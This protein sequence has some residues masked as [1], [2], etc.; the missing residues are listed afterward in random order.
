MS[1]L[2]LKSTAF[3]LVFMLISNTIF[4][5][6]VIEI[7]YERDRDGQSYTFEVVNSSFINYTVTIDFPT[8]QGLDADVGLPYETTV[9]PGTSRLLKLKPS[10]TSAGGTNFSYTSSFHKGCARTKPDTLF[11]YLLPIS[12]SKSTK[13]SE[14]FNISERYGNSSPPKNWYSL[15]FKVEEGDTV[16]AARRGIVGEVVSDKKTVGENLSFSRDVNIIEVQH[17]DCTTARY[18]LFKENGIFVKEGDVVQAGQPLGIISSNNYANG[19]QA[20]FSVCYSFVEPI[21][22]GGKKTDKNNYSAYVPVRFWVN[23]AVGKLEKNKEYTAEHPDV[24]IVKE[25][26]KREKKKRLENAKKQ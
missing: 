1:K 14:L 2:T 23:N 4:A 25:M 5:Q 12:P 15:A 6:K 21:M 26:T 13:A 18:E 3:V 7:K 17:E 11:A 10:T 24:L 9:G 22:K 19:N 16:F 20:R 8:L